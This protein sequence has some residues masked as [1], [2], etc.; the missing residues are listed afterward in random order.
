MPRA[1]VS[2][3]PEVHLEYDVRGAGDPMLLIM[4]IGAQMIFFPDD[5]CDALAARGFQVARFDNRDVGRSTW[6]DGAPTRPPGALIARRAMGLPVPAPYTLSDMARDTAGLLDHLGWDTAH[7]VGVSMGGMIAQ[8]LA[9][10]HPGRLRT[11]TSVMSTTGAVGASLP[12]P[13]ALKAL[14]Q[15]R[16]MDE[17]GAGEAL[18]RVQKALEGPLHPVSEERVRA[19]GRAAFRRGANPAGFVRQLSAVLASGDR[20]PRLRQLRVPTLVLHGEADPLVPLAGGRATAAAV[21]GARLR[22]VPGWGH[23]LPESVWP[24][25]IDEISAHAQASRG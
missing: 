4:G 2:P 17:E 15:P 3:S 13:A 16:P 7:V 1:L 14:L 23:G 25:L 18:L 19:V 8:H 22:T 9:I 6:L 5:F 10:E 11:L 21:P 12:K 20:T 24:L